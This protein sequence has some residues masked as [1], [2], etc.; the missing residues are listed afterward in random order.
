MTL[1]FKEFQKE[2][3][4]IIIGHLKISL[5]SNDILIYRGEFKDRV[6]QIIPQIGIAFKFLLDEESEPHLIDQ[7]MVCAIEDEKEREEICD[8]LFNMYKYT[9]NN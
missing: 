2:S 6:H 3:N 8:E 7:Q 4:K 5:K 1:D 9:F